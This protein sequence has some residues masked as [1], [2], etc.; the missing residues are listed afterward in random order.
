MAHDRLFIPL[1]PNVTSQK[2]WRVLRVG[3]LFGVGAI[4]GLLVSQVLRFAEHVRISGYPEGSTVVH[5]LKTP[6]TIEF[7]SEIQ[8][9]ATLISGTP[10]SIRSILTKSTSGIWLVIHDDVVVGYVTD[11]PV[12][13]AET[14]AFDYHITTN[15]E[16]TIV[17]SAAYELI[18][19]S[20]FKPSYLL[21]T[22]VDGE[23][24]QAGV[25]KALPIRMHD[26]SIVIKDFPLLQKA[27][28]TLTLPKNAQPLAAF[29]ASPELLRFMKAFEIPLVYTQSANMLN[30]LVNN[31]V[32]AVIGHDA[33]GLTVHFTTAA[34]AISSTEAAAFAKEFVELSTISSNLT[35]E[36]P[37]LRPITPGIVSVTA[38]KDLSFI[39]ATS[40][41]AL[42]SIALSSD[43]LAANNRL[44]EA[45]NIGAIEQ[46]L[47]GVTTSAYLRPHAFSDL[48]FATGKMHHL[49][50]TDLL[51]QAEAIV[52][53]NRTT[54]ICFSD[55]HRD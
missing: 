46:R 54:T 24:V 3:F 6:R 49:T 41:Q 20:S 51:T 43:T 35:D 34:G 47:C 32:S 1:T 10:F 40:E 21:R 22:R 44:I 4:A 39:T 14:D 38:E 33:S 18:V 25:E 16:Y 55:S 42:M 2:A 27:T 30:H 11:G 12:N 13:A 45:G 36:L 37:I 23:I 26:N 48:L 5:V 28:S 29:T 7:F 50:V 52:T 17:S 8:G 9:S 15:E 53:K 19:D 31:G